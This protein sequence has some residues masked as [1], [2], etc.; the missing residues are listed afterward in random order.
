MSDSY[1]PHGLQPISLLRPWDF[2]SKSTGV[3]CIRSAHIPVLPKVIF[4]KTF[5]LLCHILH[6]I[7]CMDA[8]V[9]FIHLPTERHLVCFHLLVIMTKASTNICV[10]VITWI[11][12]F[13][14]VA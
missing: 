8:P 9:L 11:Q 5:K 4:V 2:P 6:S 12:V 7:H 3:G 14:P 10:Q 13:K 1:R